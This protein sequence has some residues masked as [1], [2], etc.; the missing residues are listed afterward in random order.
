MWMEKENGE[1]EEAD[2]KGEEKRKEKTKRK[3]SVEALDLTQPLTPPDSRK[4][5]RTPLR[6]ANT[7]PCPRWPWPGLPAGAQSPPWLS[8]FCRLGRLRSTVMR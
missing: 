4:T 2:G 6:G 7:C 5:Q 1:K 3:N 8:S